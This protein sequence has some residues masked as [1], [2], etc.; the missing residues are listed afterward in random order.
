MINIMFGQTHKNI[1]TNTLSGTE[2]KTGPKESN[3]FG[4]LPKPGWK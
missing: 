4:N 2:E 3:N 1:S